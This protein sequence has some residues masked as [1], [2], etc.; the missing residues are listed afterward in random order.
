MEQILLAYGLPKE[1]VITIMIL[2]KNMK[3]KVIASDRDRHF[4]NC[5]RCSTRGY[6]SP[7]PV[8]KLPRLHTL[9]FDNLL[10]ENGFTLEKARS[11]R[12]PSQTIMDIDY[13]DDI[14]LLN[15]PRSNPCCI[16][17]SRWHRPPCE[18]RQ[19]RISPH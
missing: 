2:Y 1:I 15:L 16:A 14:A 18:C 7:K 12:Y 5:D 10:K 17:G 9:N 8:H 19:N 4:W 13:T 11:R 6:I 3:V